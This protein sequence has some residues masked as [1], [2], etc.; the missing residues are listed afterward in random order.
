MSK[1]NLVKLKKSDETVSLFR[2][3]DEIKKQINNIN[4]NVNLLKTE[5]KKSKLSDTYEPIFALKSNIKTIYSD[6]DQMKDRVTIFQNYYTED[7]KIKLFIKVNSNTF[8]N[9]LISILRELQEITSGTQLLLDN[10]IVIFD[11]TRPGTDTDPGTG[12][13]TN[14]YITNEY[15]INYDTEVYRT[16]TTTTIQD[17][18]DTK[19]KDRSEMCYIYTK[20][21]NQ[22][23][24]ELEQDITKLHQLFIDMTTQCETQ[25]EALGLI[26]HKI[27]DTIVDSQ[28]AHTV[29]AQAEKHVNSARKKF[30]LAVSIVLA[31]VVLITCAIG[32]GVVVVFMLG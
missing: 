10:D 5:Y 23:L 1:I 31:T 2:D 18:K 16:T 11:D 17:M 26:S 20:D 7:E 3:V 14:R 32:A 25:N 27:E 13:Y 19:D 21:V 24:R 4:H 15:D 22:E 8:R 30:L 29:L 6:I 28:K 12:T 9:D